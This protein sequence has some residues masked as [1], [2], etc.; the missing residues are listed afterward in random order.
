L[1]PSEVVP[2]STYIERGHR[3][4]E[5][6]EVCSLREA[7]DSME[8]QG[9]GASKSPSTADQ[10]LYEAALTEASE[11]VWQH[12]H[13][14]PSSQSGP[15]RYRPHLRKNSYAHAR[16]ASVGRYRNDII[17]TGSVRD[18]PRS[19]SGSSAEGGNLDGPAIRQSLDHS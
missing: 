6:E 13:G 14:E 18:V 8:R 17:P 9:R 10:Q 2:T 12:Q 19:I 4:M 11:L 15:Y 1:K 3:W 7:M 5:K 16:T